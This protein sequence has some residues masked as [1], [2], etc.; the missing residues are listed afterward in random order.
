MFRGVAALVLLA[1]V[2][3]ALAVENCGVSRLTRGGLSLS[4]TVRQIGSEAPTAS[5]IGVKSASGDGLLEMHTAYYEE[6]RRFIPHILYM[7]VDPRIVRLGYDGPT[8]I[9]WKTDH[10]DWIE[11]PRWSYSSANKNSYSEYFVI[12]QT[13]PKYLSFRTDLLDKLADGGKYTVSHYTKEGT[14]LMTSSVDYPDE[15]ALAALITEVRSRA[16]AGLRPC[17]PPGPSVKQAH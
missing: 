5:T 10:G 9:K 8:K 3:P 12:A 1:Q 16:V 6:G 11:Y 7:Q 14:E 4:V 17:G 13:G 2:S 15:K